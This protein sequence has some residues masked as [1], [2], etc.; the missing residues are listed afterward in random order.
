MY[1][2]YK[3]QH[4]H[5]YICTIR[6]KKCNEYLCTCV[7]ML[8]PHQKRSMWLNAHTQQS[9]PKYTTQHNTH[10]YS[11]DQCLCQIHSHQNKY[12]DQNTQHNTHM[13][14]HR[15]MSCWN[16]L[17]PKQLYRALTP[18]QVCSTLTPKQLYRALTPKQVCSTLT[19]KQLYRALTLKQVCRALTPKQV[20]K[21][22]THKV[23][24]HD[25]VDRA[26]VR[27]KGVVEHAREADH[28]EPAVLDLGTLRTSAYGGRGK[29]GG[30]RRR[31]DGDLQCW[32]R[33]K[34]FRCQTKTGWAGS[35]RFLTKN[36]FI[37]DF[38]HFNQ[39]RV[40]PARPDFWKIN[41]FQTILTILTII[42]L[43]QLKPTLGNKR[44]EKIWQ[45]EQ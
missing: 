42:G 41:I 39:S 18:K 1:M 11:T 29:Q 37:T 5:W 23:R 3:S 28:C 9:R 45:I 4:T 33:I 31:R 34:I 24:G 44:F 38:D 8:S 25:L 6:N 21:D 22:E 17:T 32:V 26:L 30:E 12:V 35:T 15:P 40:E 27:D 43:Q 7:C 16:T 10:M 2:V 36:L 13:H 20:C 14:S 19:P